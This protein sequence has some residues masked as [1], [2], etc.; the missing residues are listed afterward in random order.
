MA[1]ESMIAREH[2]R[3]KTVKKYAAKRAALKA[4]LSD[5]KNQMEKSKSLD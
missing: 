4:I 3:L 1:K 2:K 5:T